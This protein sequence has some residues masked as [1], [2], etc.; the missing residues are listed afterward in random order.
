M[1]GDLSGRKICVTCGR[2]LLGNIGLEAHG[3]YMHPVI[4]CVCNHRFF[5][6]ANFWLHARRELRNISN[7][8]VA[9]IISTIQ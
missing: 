7:G 9:E 5:T 8:L 1:P 3:L 4:G 6:V 2:S